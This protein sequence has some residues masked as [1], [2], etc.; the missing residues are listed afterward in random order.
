[1]PIKNINNVNYL[2]GLSPTANPARLAVTGNSCRA[3]RA[4]PAAPD[5]RSPPRWRRDCRRALPRGARNL[6]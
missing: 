1:V 4:N 6:G 3:A 2:I 5:V